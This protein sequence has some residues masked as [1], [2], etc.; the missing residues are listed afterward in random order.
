MAFHN[1]RRLGLYPITTLFRIARTSM[2]ACSM[3]DWISARRCLKIY[4]W[5]QQGAVIAKQWCGGGGT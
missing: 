5:A 3:E 4:S 2:G 1:L